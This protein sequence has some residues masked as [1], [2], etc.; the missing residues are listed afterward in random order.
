MAKMKMRNPISLP[1]GGASQANINKALEEQA[2]Y[3]RNVVQKSVA[4]LDLESNHTETITANGTTVINPAE[5]KDGMEKTTVT[6]AVPLEDNKA[7]TIDVSQYESAVEVT[8]T[9][10]K[11]A[12]KKT[13]VTLSNIPQIEA[14]KE[15]SITQ[16]GTVEVTPTSGKQGMAKATV[17]VAVP[18]AD[19]ESNKAA[20]I[21]VSE[22]TEPVEVTPTSGKDGM[23]K[24]TITLSNIPSGADLEANKT[25]TINVS[26]YTEPV[27]I[28]PTQGKDGM[29]KVT[30]SLSNM[31]AGANMLYAWSFEVDGSVFYVYL[32]INISPD[33]LQGLK[34]VT[35]I[36]QDPETGLIDKV[37]GFIDNEEY[38]KTSDSVFVTDDVTYTRDDTKDVEVWNAPPEVE[39]TKQATIDV[40]TY[41]PAN[42]PVIT[43][44]AGKQSMGSVEITLSNIPSGG[45]TAYCWILYDNYDIAVYFNFSVAPNTF[46]FE[47]I[48]SGSIKQDHIIYFVVAAD[49]ADIPPSAEL[50][51]NRVSDTEFTISYTV[52]GERYTDTYTRDSTK[53][54]TLW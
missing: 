1:A 40:S 13:T 39:T 24:A 17:T 31:P 44:T 48:K 23:A 25:A 45:A 20:T 34:S 12:M 3:L 29:E 38:T 47:T 49:W 35:N 21:D 30:V 14:N 43:P 9:S 42:K 26:T 52:D 22:Y 15:A 28:T 2:D 50:A 27:E 41:D 16:N 5:G 37:N 11:T 32:D 19:I 54:F 4:G 8:P 7:S 36:L 53:D 51:Y 18:S 10:G 33:N 46:D 6:V